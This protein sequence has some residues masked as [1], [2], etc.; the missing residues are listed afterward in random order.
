M[1]IPAFEKTVSTPGNVLNTRLLAYVDHTF[2][3]VTLMLCLFRYTSLHRFLLV[4]P[5]VL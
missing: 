5:L 4:S 3:A 1:L 2:R